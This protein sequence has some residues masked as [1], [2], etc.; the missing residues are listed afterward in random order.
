[1]ATLAP[2]HPGDILRHEFLEPLGMSARALARDLG[3][4]ANRVTEITSG[5]RR[6][7]AESAIALAGRFGTS[8]EFWLN[9]QSAYDLELAGYVRAAPIA[10]TAA[11]G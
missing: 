9:L 11:N 3:W 8:A 5:S 2:V 1:M 10:E 6:I 7:T 4:P